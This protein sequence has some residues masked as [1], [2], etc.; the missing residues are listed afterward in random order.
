MVRVEL[1]WTFPLRFVELISGDGTKVYRERIDVLGFRRRSTRRT[2]A[3][4]T[5]PHWPHLG[6][7]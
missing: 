1:S 5:G 3:P 7:V 6:S 4:P 2:T